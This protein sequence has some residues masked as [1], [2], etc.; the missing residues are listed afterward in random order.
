MA[1]YPRFVY[2]DRDLYDVLEQATDEEL[3]MLVGLMCSRV[4]SSIHGAC[5][6]IPAIVDEFQRFG[7]HTVLNTLRGHGVRYAEIVNDVAARVGA[8]LHGCQ[9]ISEKEWCI[10]ECLDKSAEE[11]MDE[12][13]KTKFYQD[14][15][16]LNNATNPR[17]MVDPAA[18]AYSVTVPGVML[19]AMIRT[20]VAAQETYQYIRGC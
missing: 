19:I 2:S 3:A 5:R 15:L 17:D 8:D 16:R 20:R 7:G 10:V 9:S 13:N 12:E 18:P 11:K 1:K 4:S 6:D 14:V